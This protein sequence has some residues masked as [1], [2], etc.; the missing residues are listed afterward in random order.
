MCKLLSIAT[1]IPLSCRTEEFNEELRMNNEEWLRRAVIF[2]IEHLTFYNCGV[3][4]SFAVLERMI[5]PL[6]R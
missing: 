6:F 4:L 1:R 3:L 2:N 5:L